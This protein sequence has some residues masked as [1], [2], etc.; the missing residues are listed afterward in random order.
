M[1]GDALIQSR[2]DFEA[3]PFDEIEE[4]YFS[5]H[6][7]SFRLLGETMLPGMK[8]VGGVGNGV[9]EIAQD[10]VGYQ[11]L[12]MLSVDDPELYAQL[13][14]T[15]GDIMV[16]IWTRVL[17]EF[18]DIFA[19]CRFGDDLGFKSSTLLSPADIRTHILPQYR[20]VVDLV[21]ARGKPFLLHCCGNILAV[22]DDIIDVV[23]IDAKHSNEDQ[24]APFADWVDRYND[25]IG[26]FG[27]VDMDLLCRAGEQSIR[28]CVADVMG[29]ASG[30]GG[31]ALGSGNSIPDYVP[32]S[33]YLAMI[34]TV[35]N[36]RGDY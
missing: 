6:A 12:C 15:I 11:Q 27:G 32:A 23:T 24:I 28:E 20:R 21:H 33:G 9:F 16:T 8:A 30:R 31:L 34:E 2:Q 5:W 10:L 1:L 29:H 13:F 19:V 3:Y 17:E 18:G 26:L 25:R 22:M 4:K 36:L 7:D 35:R 14:A